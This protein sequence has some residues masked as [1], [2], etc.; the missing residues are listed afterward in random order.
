MAVTRCDLYWLFK[1]LVAAVNAAPAGTFTPV[2]DDPRRSPG[3][4]L[5]ALQ[6]ADDEV[7]TLLASTEGHGYRSLF[8]ADSTDLSHG[9]QL[10]DH[11]GPPGQLKIK[12]TSADSDYK[13]AKFDEH[14]SLADIERWRANPGSIYGAN[15]DASGSVLSGYGRIIGKEVFFTGHRAKAKLATYTHLSR[16]V[17]D[18]A[19]NTG[20]KTLNSATAA[21]TAAD[22]GGAALV[23]GG[24]ASGVPL[25]SRI[26]AYVG[27]TSVTLRDANASGGNISAKAAVVAK[28]QAPQDLEGAVFCLAMTMMPKRGDSSPFL[29]VFVRGAETRM[30]AIA[31]GALVVPNTEA[32]QAA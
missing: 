22:A 24:G 7:C 17:T 6:A 31:S 26:D 1:R 9:D 32:A 14:L 8:T 25:L 20:S 3:E 12:H 2:L 27:A 5:A 19:M 18:A 10:P 23:D 21:F 4:I 16:E 15:H 28:L 11:L 29:E 30:G 13:A